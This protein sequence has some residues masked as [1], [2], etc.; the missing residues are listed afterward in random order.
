MTDFD[1]IGIGH[2]VVKTHP[3][4]ACTPPCP[5]HSPSEHPLKDA[6]LHWRGDRRIWERIC[7]HGIGHNDPDSTAYNNQHGISDDGSHG[8]DGCCVAAHIEGDPNA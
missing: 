2:Q 4:L 3:E 1:L 7:S 8:C 6:P 5:V